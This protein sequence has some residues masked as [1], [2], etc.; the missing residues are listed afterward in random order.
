MRG[1]HKGVS[2][3]YATAP[4]D[5][6]ATMK[7]VYCLSYLPPPPP[8]VSTPPPGGGPSPAGSKK[9]TQQCHIAQDCIIMRACCLSLCVPPLC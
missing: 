8:P 6:Q 1:M 2:K 5:T 7:A 4:H 3:A 9:K